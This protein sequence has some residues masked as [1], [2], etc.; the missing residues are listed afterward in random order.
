MIE[1]V[2]QICG[3]IFTI[4]VKKTEINYI[5]NPKEILFGIDD[6]DLTI[7]NIVNILAKNTYLNAHKIQTFP[8]F[9]EIFRKSGKQRKA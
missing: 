7:F 4:C 9:K 1:C 5:P 3:Q 8:I 2:I 6:P